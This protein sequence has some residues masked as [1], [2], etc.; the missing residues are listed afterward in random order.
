MA[1]STQPKPQNDAYTGILFISLLALIGACAL[2]YMDYDQYGART[3]PKGTQLE[4]PNKSID[5]GTISPTIP[6]PAPGGNEPK[7]NEPMTMKPPVKPNETELTLVRPDI[8]APPTAPATIPTLQ[9]PGLPPMPVVTSDEGAIRPA[10]FETLAPVKSG[11]D[12]TS[13]EVSKPVEPMKELEVL[14]PA[15]ETKPTVELKPVPETK[16]TAPTT[17]PSLLDAP[18]VSRPFVPGK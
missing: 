12:A 5:K 15:E 9:V 3:P 13:R 6:L 1:A 11:V 17:P 14:P 4:T 18:P 10:K 16:P 7:K 2:L 8:Q